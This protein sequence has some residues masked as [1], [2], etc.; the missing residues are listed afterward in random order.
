MSSHRNVVMFAFRMPINAGKPWSDT[1][2]S[3]LLDFDEQRKSIEETAEFLCR[4]E[5][6]VRE[7]IEALKCKTR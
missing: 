6:E 1:D 2:D 3:A 7:R 4:T 5:D